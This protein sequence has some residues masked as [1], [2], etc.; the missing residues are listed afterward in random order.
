V[1]YQRLLER[2]I[3]REVLDDWNDANNS[4]LTKDQDLEIQTRVKAIVAAA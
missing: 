3:Y 1:R 2:C 4:P